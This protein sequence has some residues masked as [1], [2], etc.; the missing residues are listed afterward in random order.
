MESHL[1]DSERSKG[2][3]RN[4]KSTKTVKSSVGTFE[5]ETPTERQSSFQPDLVKKRKIILADNLS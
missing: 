1:S 5:L 4:G 3:K 2:N